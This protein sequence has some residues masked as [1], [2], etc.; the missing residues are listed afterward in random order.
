LHNL[1]A[2]FGELNAGLTLL[3]LGLLFLCPPAAAAC[4]I[5]A[6]VLGAAQLA[7]DATRRVHGEQVSGASLGLELAVAIPI[8]GNVVRGLRAAENVTH[9]VPGGGLMAHEGLG[10]AHTLTK[11]VGKTPEFLRNRL[12]TEPNIH[13]A[14]SFYDR[15]VAENSLSS[16]MATN[17]R[18]IRQWLDEGSFQLVLRGRFPYSVGTMIARGGINLVHA[19]GLKVI[20]RRDESLPTHFRIHTAMVMS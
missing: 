11:H 20:L 5:T 2:G 3:G 8:G 13:A 15:Q 18:Q 19:S 12:D 4:L 17:D 10:G 16:F 1:S 6:T 14:S 9:L 7:V